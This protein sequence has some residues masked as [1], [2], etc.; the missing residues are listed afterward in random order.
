M[1]P[2][3]VLVAQNEVSVPQVSEMGGDYIIV[4]YK[5]YDGVKY[6]ADMKSMD[7][8]VFGNTLLV[9]GF[10]QVGSPDFEAAYD[11]TAGTISI[12]A[13]IKLFGDGDGMV[14]YLYLWDADNSEASESPIEYVYE[15][16]GV[17]K[18][19]RTLVLMSGVEGEE[20]SPYYFSQGSVIYRAN[21]VTENISF[22]GSGDSQERY[23][24]SRPS[25][26]EIDN[27][28]VTVYNL[29][30]TDQ[31][32]YGCK[33]EGT[34]NAATGEVVFSPEV[35]GQSNEGVYKV[36]AGC[37]YD[38]AK[39]F[40]TDV[41]EA[42][43]GSEGVVKG[44]IDLDAGVLTLEPMAIWVGNYSNGVVTIQKSV[45]EFVRS[46]E[47]KFENVQMG[48]VETLP[49]NDGDK[50]VLKVEYYN[51]MGQRLVQPVPDTFAIKRTYYKGHQPETE[52]V[53]IK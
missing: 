53:Y 32:G 22:A 19:E 4:N 10:Y 34:Y 44:A 45:F 14:Q 8:R 52:K 29:L 39:N 7:F 30:Q 46:V 28:K 26:L 40:P 27:N 38:E 6:V 50:E 31:Y 21:A 12:S 2:A 36:L 23:E 51:L 18:E 16:N 25:Y 5:D 3:G 15:G 48:S 1:L 33:M 17:W 37:I 11:E 20:L 24:E 47:V 42:G 41:T 13:G 9:S 43:T 49:G 35:V